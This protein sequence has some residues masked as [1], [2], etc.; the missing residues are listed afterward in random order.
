MVSVHH[1]HLPAELSTEC[2]QL[3]ASEL[4][5]P[6]VDVYATKAEQTVASC[7]T[8]NLGKSNAVTQVVWQTV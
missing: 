1:R 4:T 8:L 2:H 6:K 5:V 3:A 7:H